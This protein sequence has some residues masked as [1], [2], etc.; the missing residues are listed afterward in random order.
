MV[1]RG[2][3][4]GGGCRGE[5]RGGPR[6]VPRDMEEGRHL[7]LVAGQR[8]RVHPHKEDRT[9]PG[10]MVGFTWTGRNRERSQKVELLSKDS[11]AG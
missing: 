1:S 4:R 6:R 3:C 5:Q 9:W 2:W 10:R 11:E 8:E 7:A